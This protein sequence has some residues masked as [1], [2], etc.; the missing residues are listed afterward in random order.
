MAETSNNSTVFTFYKDVQNELDNHFSKALSSP[1]ENASSHSA[2]S[3]LSSSSSSSIL[4]PLSAPPL[5]SCSTTSP[6][7][8]VS[9]YSTGQVSSPTFIYPPIFPGNSPST[10]S[11]RMRLQILH[12]E[13]SNYLIYPDIDTFHDLPKVPG[14]SDFPGPPPKVQLSDTVVYPPSFLASPGLTP[15][16]GTVPYRPAVMDM[17]P[18]QQMVYQNRPLSWDWQEHTRTDPNSS[19]SI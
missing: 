5:Q 17:S 15:Q 12:P 8:V 9:P 13:M 19:S 7:Q 2:T 6:L 16:A 1:A 3:L 11:S 18:R 4:P 14:Q 10:T